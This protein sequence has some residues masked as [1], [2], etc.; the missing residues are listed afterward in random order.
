[1]HALSSSSHAM[2]YAY[3]GNRFIQEVCFHSQKCHNQAIESNESRDIKANGT[4][5]GVCLKG[6]T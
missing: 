4:D 1:M 3:K 5:M 6:G 2:N